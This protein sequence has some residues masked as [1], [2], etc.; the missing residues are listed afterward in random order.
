MT[1]EET[2]TDSFREKNV[3]FLSKALFDIDLT[4]GQEAI[5]RQIA[6]S[7]H[8]RI[9]I[10]AM[11]RY[12]KTLCVSLGI[13]LYILLNK[14]KRICII[15]P[16]KEQAEVV[17]DYLSVL[18]TTCPMLLAV[19]EITASGPL[20]LDKEASKKRLTFKNGCEYEVFS[21]EGDANRLMGHGGDVVIVDEACLIDFEVYGKIMRMLGDDAS[22]SILI[23]LFNPWDR[24]TKA[25]EHWNDPIYFKL[26]IPWQQAVRE[27][28]TTAEFVEEQ[29]KELTSLQFTVLYDSEFPDKAE[30]AVHTLTD[31]QKALILPK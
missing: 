2:L 24:S 4:D 11:T 28:R 8:R 27:G 1:L 7:E 26:K 5:V 31:I 22:G 9:C 3:K 10:S 30:D 18:I 21:A 12:G 25:F 6:F 29:R 20:R 14:D 23:E 19:A 16:Q 17:K 15:G 13:A